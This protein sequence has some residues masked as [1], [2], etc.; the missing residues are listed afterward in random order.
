MSGSDHRFGSEEV[1]ELLQDRVTRAELH[2]VKATLE[3]LRSL[4][5]GSSLRGMESEITSVKFTLDETRR[6]IARFQHDAVSQRD[7][8]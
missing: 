1:H 7:L 3:D 8:A 4:Q 2:S 6:E 5:G